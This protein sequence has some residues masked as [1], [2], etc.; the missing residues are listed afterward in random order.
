MYYLYCLRVNIRLQS[1]FCI[2][3]INWERDVGKR[4]FSFVFSI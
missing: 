3:K 4:P 2:V 1:V